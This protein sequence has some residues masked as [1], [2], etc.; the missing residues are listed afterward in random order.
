[1]EVQLTNILDI[2]LANDD[3]SL[4]IEVMG[5]LRKTIE[6]TEA[7]TGFKRKDKIDLELREELRNF[8]VDFCESAGINEE[9]E[10]VEE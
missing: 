1:M 9:Q 7:S 8:I 3:V 4:F 2:R 10:Y 5:T 6:E